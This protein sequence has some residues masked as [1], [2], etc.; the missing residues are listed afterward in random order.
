MRIGLFGF[1]FGMWVLILL[2]GG[3]V[4][5]VLGPISI[6]GYGEMD[7]LLSSGIKAV[8]AII[9]VITWILILSKLKNWIFRK[10]IHP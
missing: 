4:V 5:V 3:I 1:L 10:E 6:S 2:G 7:W 9:L 8:I